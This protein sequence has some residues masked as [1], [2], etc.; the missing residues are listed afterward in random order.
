[1]W[2]TLGPVIISITYMTYDVIIFLFLFF[3]VYLSFTF[4]TVYVYDV[5]SDARTSYFNSHKVCQSRLNLRENLILNILHLSQKRA[6]NLFFWAMIRTGNPHFADIRVY[7][8][9]KTYDASC[10]GKLTAEGGEVPYSDVEVC[11]RG[12]YT[13][14]GIDRSNAYCASR[15]DFL[16]FL[17]RTECVRSTNLITSTEYVFP[18][19]VCLMMR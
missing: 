14:L 5:Y 13:Y 8:A 4:A 15:L 6:F 17:L 12:L 11:G 10:L 1:M 16:K 18:N 9:T 2:R 3:I 19:Q 7:N